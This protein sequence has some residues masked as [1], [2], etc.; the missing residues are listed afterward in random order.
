MSARI[1]AMLQKSP[2]VIPGRTTEHLDGPTQ[3]TAFFH[4]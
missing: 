2:A 3:A 1:K 4:L